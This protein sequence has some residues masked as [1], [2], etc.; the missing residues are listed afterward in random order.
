MA[1]TLKPNGEFVVVEELHTKA[2][3]PKRYTLADAEKELRESKACGQFVVI[4]ANGG[5]RQM[6]F[7]EKQEVDVE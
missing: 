1:K 5:V 7:L 4:F 6:H 3:F 2:V